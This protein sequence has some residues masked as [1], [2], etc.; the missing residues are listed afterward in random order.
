MGSEMCIRDRF[1]DHV[2]SLYMVWAAPLDDAL[3]VFKVDLKQGCLLKNWIRITPKAKTFQIAR[4]STLGA[5]LFDG[6]EDMHMIETFDFKSEKN[7]D[8]HSTISL[9]IVSGCKI[10]RTKKA[11][12]EQVYKEW[13]V[14]EV[15]DKLYLIFIPINDR[16]KI[17]CQVLDAEDKCWTD[18]CTLEVA[19]VAGVGRPF[20]CGGEHYL[21]LEIQHDGSN[22]TSQQVYRFDVE[23]KALC[24][25][26]MQ[27]PSDLDICVLPQYILK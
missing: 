4:C 2:D 18:Y 19:D 17:F 16:S 11:K 23:K 24:D 7:S 20:K 27:I 1:Y 12:C 14:I 3:K 25:M 5:V 8:N 26:G 9:N 21:I 15:E 22:D 13:S 6:A 10:N